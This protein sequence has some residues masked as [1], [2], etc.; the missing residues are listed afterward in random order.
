MVFLQFFTCIAG[1]YERRN[2][3]TRSRERWCK[4]KKRRYAAAFFFFNFVYIL[5]Y[6]T[7]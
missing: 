2:V 3:E 1:V 4:K 6:S 5:F 7:I